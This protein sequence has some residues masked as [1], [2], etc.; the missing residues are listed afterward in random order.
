MQLQYPFTEYMKWYLQV[1]DLFEG[2]ENVEKREQELWSILESLFTELTEI[3]PYENLRNDQ[4]RVN[5]KLC[6]AGNAV[7]GLTL[8]GLREKQ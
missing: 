2:V 1:Q 8:A 5:Y 6:C 3:A 4:E 7:I